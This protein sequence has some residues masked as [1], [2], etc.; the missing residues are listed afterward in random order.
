MH[1][2]VFVKRNLVD[3]VEVNL[4]FIPSYGTNF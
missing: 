2:F 4:A 3:F 1:L